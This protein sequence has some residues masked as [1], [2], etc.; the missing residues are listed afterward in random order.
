MT[1]KLWKQL[2]A[3][4]LAV[5]C[6]VSVGVW[7]AARSDVGDTGAILIPLDQHATDWILSDDNAIIRLVNEM[8]EDG[9]PV[10]WALKDF[11]VDGE[12][13]PAGT[14]YIPT[15]F[16]TNE[17]MTSDAVYEWL[18]WEAKLHRVYTISRTDEQV[19]VESKALVMPRVV[20][21]YDNTTYDNCL[22]HYIRMTDLGFKVQLATAKE[23]N[24]YAWDDPQGVLAK[25]NVFAMP[26]GVLHFWSFVDQA[27]G[28]AN[29]RSFVENGGGYV[30]VCA[31][32]SEALSK[33][34]F[35]YLSLLDANYHAEWFTFEEL[36]DGDWDWRNLIGPIFLEIEQTDHP[37]TF[38][39]G[40]DAIRPGYGDRTTMYYYGGPAMHDLDEEVVSLAT[41]AAPVTQIT[42]EKVSNIWGATAV[43][44]QEFGDGNAVLFGPHPEWP[45][46][47]ARMY[48]QALYFTAKLDVDT[49][50]VPVTT[51]VPGSIDNARVSA[52]TDTVADI[53]PILEDITRMAADIVNL[54]A[55]DHYHP[56]GMWYDE[57]IMVYGQTVY[58]HL[59]EIQGDAR[60]FQFEYR[61]LSLLLEKAESE[62][63]RAQIQHALDMIELFYQTTENM[64]INDK[65]VGK[66]DWSGA[67]PFERF[68]D[69]KE[70]TTFTAL[71]PVFEFMKMDMETSAVPYA[72]D[73]A[74]LFFQYEELRLIADLEGTEEAE[75]A[76]DALYDQMAS[77]S[78]AGDMYVVQAAL[79]HVLKTMQY[80]A[81]YPLLNIMT[82]A[83]RVSEVISTAN[84]AAA[85][86][87]GSTAYAAATARAFIEHPIGGILP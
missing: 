63:T 82:V 1:R 3:V 58:D 37:V 2:A 70:P 20:L 15:P 47:C 18:Q 50:I 28:I 21:F 6:I 64:K 59:N 77:E 22:Q 11:T 56:L 51:A 23:I 45:G 76:C 5:V 84:Y 73:Y 32:S 53:K 66:T 72:Y 8:L 49:T 43:A 69:E 17:G 54:K 61:R 26:G 86:D 34:P 31:G 27:L 44:T 55:G 10:Q 12:T 14:F 68:P 79:A 62:Q 67:G 46:P 39:Y 71:T 30:G 35:E 9:V 24:E 16:V 19:S 60:K 87:V 7:D 36:S 25:A 33:S 80:K 78:P 4:A 65:V 29:I 57:P 74:E 42:G 85:L 48:A 40:R 83:H 38:G 81:D 41:Y 52:I 13:F 75:A